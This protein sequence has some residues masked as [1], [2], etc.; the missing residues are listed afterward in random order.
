VG[1][2]PV[3][4]L[5][6]LQHVVEVFGVQRGFAAVAGE[7]AVA[8]ELGLGGLRQRLGVGHRHRRGQV[9]QPA[10]DHVQRDACV[11][12]AGRRG[13]LYLIL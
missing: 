6:Q 4:A 1:Q 2:D 13:Y 3:G 8:Q 12:Q 7:L 5:V 9:P 11:Q 10:L